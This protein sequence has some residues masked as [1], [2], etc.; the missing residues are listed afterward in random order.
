M[1]KTQGRGRPSFEGRSKCGAKAG[2][3]PRVRGFE[4]GSTFAQTTRKNGAPSD[5]YKVHVSR[6]YF[7]RKVGHPPDAMVLLCVT[8]TLLLLGR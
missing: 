7:L 8:E 4:R 3:A 5:G 6:V 1:Q 2:H